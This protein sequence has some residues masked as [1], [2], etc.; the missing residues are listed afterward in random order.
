MTVG[1]TSAVPE[2][3]AAFSVA[4]PDGA[5]LPVYAFGGPAHA[6]G[7]LFGHANGLA[8]GSYAPWL[9][10]LAGALRIFA[11]DARGH[12]GSRWPGGAVE[13]VFSPRRLPRR[14]GRGAAAAPA[15]GGGAPPPS[16]GASPATAPP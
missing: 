10:E 4:T 5:V 1:D 7:L 9:H 2:N 15:R 16:C 11:F 12:G 13:A 6:P 8:A 3:A 14:F